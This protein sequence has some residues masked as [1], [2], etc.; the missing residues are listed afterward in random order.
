MPHCP[1]TRHRRACRLERGADTESELFPQ[2]RRRQAHD[3]RD[4]GLDIAAGR[5]IAL[6]GRSGAGKST[7]LALLRGPL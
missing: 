2:S 3:L 6:I 5:K 1:R 7:L 4:I